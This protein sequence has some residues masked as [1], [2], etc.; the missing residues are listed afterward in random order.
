M[1][2]SV[3]KIFEEDLKTWTPSFAFMVSSIDNY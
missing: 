2:P 3:K 1:T